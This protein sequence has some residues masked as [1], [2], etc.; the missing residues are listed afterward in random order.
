MFNFWKKKE[1]TPEEL[2]EFNRVKVKE[3]QSY[4]SGT[5]VAQMTLDF[6]REFREIYGS[7]TMYN[8]IAI[9]PLQSFIGLAIKNG[10]LKK[11]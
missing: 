6:Q 3:V 11:V 1:I 2:R 5:D 7:D 10:Y 4:V 9:G 8:F